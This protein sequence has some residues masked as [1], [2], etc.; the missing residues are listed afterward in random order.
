MSRR[1]SEER[2]RA[3]T[4]A[5]AHDVEEDGERGS[6][7]H[8]EDVEIELIRLLHAL[9]G[10]I[11][12]HAG[13]DPDGEHR[14]ERAHDLCARTRTYEYTHTHTRTH[15]QTS[16]SHTHR[17]TQRHTQRHTHRERERERER[18]RGERE[19]VREREEREIA[20]TSR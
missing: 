12:E 18:G 5:H 4:S 2:E 16:T 19:R 15:T 13:H 20:S 1:T 11:D 14:E 8:R 7:E 10:Q 9:D 17:H 3:G 6:D